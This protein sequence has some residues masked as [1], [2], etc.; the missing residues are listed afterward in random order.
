MVKKT[1][2]RGIRKYFA[3]EAGFN[4]SWGSVFAGIATFL[5]VLILLSLL[6]SAI[7]FGTIQPTGGGSLFQG[8]KP[9]LIIWGILTFIISFL[10]A[11]FIAGMASRRIGML[12]GFLTWAGSVIVLLLMVSMLASSIFSAAGSLISG[13]FSVAG[14]AA[15]GAG[16]LIS[17]GVDEATQSLG[18]VDT[19]E[20]ETQINNIL[21][22]TDVPELQPGYIQDQLDGATSDI[23]SAGKDLVLNPENSDQIISE[24]TQSLQERADTIS[25]AADEDAIAN[26]VEENTDLTGAE[27]Q[28]AT[29]NITNALQSAS[30]NAQQAINQASD[31]LNQLEQNVREAADTATNAATQTSIWTFVALLVGMVLSTLAGIWGSNFVGARDEEVM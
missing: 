6:G 22:D 15:S 10:A 31:S 28:E 24:T 30:D 14:D 5:A 26:A 20:A 9:A 11:G 19:Q 29:N 3:A 18:N 27:A 8:T 1:E 13:A 17:T 2:A 25:N 4:I 7:G 12:H 21:Q 23:T 16:D